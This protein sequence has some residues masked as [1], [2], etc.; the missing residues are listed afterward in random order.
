MLSDSKHIQ[1]AMKL[2]SVFKPCGISLRFVA[3]LVTCSAILNH[4]SATD[5]TL[6]GQRR[7][8]DQNFNGVSADAGQTGELKQS[9]LHREQRASKTNA[10]P[11]QRDIEKRLKAV[12]QR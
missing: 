11:K 1:S 12:E 3:V 5:D 9:L 8:E 6:E 4:I 2:F 10:T 7:G